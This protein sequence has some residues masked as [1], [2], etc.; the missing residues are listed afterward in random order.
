MLR[1]LWLFFLLATVL[2]LFFYRPPKGHGPDMVVRQLFV[3]SIP[4]TASF[5]VALV[6]A[7]K[8]P[9][10]SPF[11]FE[12]VITVLVAITVAVLYVSVFMP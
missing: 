10:V 8:R 11:P 12:L 2:M 9:A 1:L 3:L 4:T 7:A 5:V 6:L